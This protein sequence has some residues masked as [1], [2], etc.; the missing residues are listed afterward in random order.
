MLSILYILIFHNSLCI[1]LWLNLSWVFKRLLPDLKLD[2][3]L[4]YIIIVH[5]ERII[6]LIFKNQSIYFDEPNPARAKVSSPEGLPDWVMDEL[7]TSEHKLNESWKL[8]SGEDYSLVQSP[9]DIHRY[10]VKMGFK[11]DSSF[12]LSLGLVHM[13]FFL[14]GFF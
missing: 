7:G 3:N 5:F 9:A 11:H 1:F 4:N 8:S 2:G 10:A 6:F 14:V 12:S 13:L